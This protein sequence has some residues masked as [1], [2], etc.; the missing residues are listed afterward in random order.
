MISI[1][2]WAD[3]PVNPK[4]EYFDDQNESTSLK[5]LSK[6]AWQSTECFRS[7]VVFVTVSLATLTLTRNRSNMSHFIW[8]IYNGS[9]KGRY[10]SIFRNNLGT[11]N[12]FYL[13]VH[14]QSTGCHQRNNLERYSASNPR[15]MTNLKLISKN[16]AF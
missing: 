10:E 12:I 3:G 6:S 5:T 1:L 2:I 9:S 8:V 15:K 16:R 13:F 7:K 14:V 11:K 4:L